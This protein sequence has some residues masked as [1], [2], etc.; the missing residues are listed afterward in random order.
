MEVD[1]LQY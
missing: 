1:W